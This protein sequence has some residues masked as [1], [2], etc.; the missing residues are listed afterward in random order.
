MSRT[1]TIPDAS[2]IEIMAKLPI[3]G[4][5]WLIEG[6]HL[7]KVLIARAVVTPA[8]NG[9]PIRIA[10]TSIMP[11][12]LYQGTRVATAELITETSINAVTESLSE[13]GHSLGH[14]CMEVPLHTPLAADLTEDQREQFLAV[15]SYY[16]DILA[17]NDD[18]LGRTNVL[19]HKIE[20]GVA[21]PI[22][23]QARRVPLPHR[24]KVQEL[25]QDML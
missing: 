17:K 6:R 11:V 13:E 1:T 10:N 2:E 14:E 21:K 24:E 15:L 3:R 9:I 16:S 18:D 7:D 22:R 23:Q 19:R 12:S 4:G 5:P 20:T 8:E 25:L